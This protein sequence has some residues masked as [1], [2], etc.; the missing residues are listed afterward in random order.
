MC[1]CVCTCQQATDR[2]VYGD[3]V[4]GHLVS[5]GVHAVTCQTQ[6]DRLLAIREATVALTERAQ[7]LPVCF[8]QHTLLVHRNTHTHIAQCELQCRERELNDW[9]DEG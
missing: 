6:A 5:E 1:V 4:L 3:L 9:L 8:N 2:Q 7:T